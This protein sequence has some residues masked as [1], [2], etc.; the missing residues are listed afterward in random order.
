MLPP[1][2]KGKGERPDG[3]LPID[4][5][6]RSESLD[7]DEAEPL[8]FGLGG[9][10]PLFCEDNFDGRRGVNECER[11]CTCDDVDEAGVS[12]GVMG[13]GLVNGGPRRA[14]FGGEVDTSET[15]GKG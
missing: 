10:R 11:E 13:D 2:P 4:A 14:F 5:L 15:T 3:P 1:K 8:R 9:R 6:S 7:S 12:G